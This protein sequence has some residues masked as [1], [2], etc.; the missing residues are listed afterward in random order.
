MGSVISQ[1]KIPS[2]AP[3]FYRINLKFLARPWQYSPNHLLAPS[4]TVF[5]LLLSSSAPL[6]LA[7]Y[8]QTSYTR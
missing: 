6:P 1:L 2:V 5:S 4:P 7:L 3:I 8:I